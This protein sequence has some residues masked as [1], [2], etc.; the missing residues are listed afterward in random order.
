MLLP[1]AGGAGAAGFWAGPALKLKPEPPVEPAAG[2]VVGAPE[3]PKLNPEL[4]ELCK[5][6]KI[7]QI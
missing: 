3:P 2:C 6:R 7:H 1:A 4:L 5:E